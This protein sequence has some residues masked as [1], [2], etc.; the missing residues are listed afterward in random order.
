MS[1]AITKAVEALTK[2]IDHWGDENPDDDWD[3]IRDAREALT[4]LQ[5]QPAPVW[6]KPLPVLHIVF[7]GPPSH[8]GGRF[9]EVE[10]PDGK[11]IRA[12]EWRERSDG[13]WELRLSALQPSPASDPRLDEL[14]KLVN[15]LDGLTENL[16]REETRARAEPLAVAYANGVGFANVAIRN[17]IASLR[18][19][20]PALIGMVRHLTPYV[21]AFRREES[22]A[23]DLAL[24]VD[25]AEVRATAAE[26]RVAEAYEQAARIADAMQAKIDARLKKLEKPNADLAGAAA[27]GAADAAQKIAAQIRALGRAGT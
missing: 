7:D 4:A 26:A 24:K 15:A 10:T 20:T 12:G 16:T 3:A 11:S 2:C 19:A 18:E 9:V 8:D 14:E 21:E 22:R 6:V 25:E 13:L 27:V 5:E 23:D 17:V 1:E